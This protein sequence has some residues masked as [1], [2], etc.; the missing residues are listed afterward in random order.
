MGQRE[1]P[2]ES[3][4]GKRVRTQLVVLEHDFCCAVETM[5]TLPLKRAKLSLK[6]IRNSWRCI[7]FLGQTDRACDGQGIGDIWRCPWQILN[8]E[9]F[10]CDGRKIGS[11]VTAEPVGRGK[12]LVVP[13]RWL[14]L[15]R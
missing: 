15:E 12:K 11:Y 4:C 6:I 9:Q 14:L 8:D 2:D 5:D 13:L 1:C 7:G 10:N 3:V